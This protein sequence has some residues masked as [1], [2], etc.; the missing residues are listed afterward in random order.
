M[1]PK[2]KLEV[3]GCNDMMMRVQGLEVDR[4]K[5]KVMLRV[6]MRRMKTHLKKL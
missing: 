3:K 1:Q 6:M 5:T 2:L 4:I